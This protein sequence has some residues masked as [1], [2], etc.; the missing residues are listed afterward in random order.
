MKT[1]VLKKD[2][3]K[4]I[5]LTIIVAL[6]PLIQHQLITGTLVN[7]ILFI[8]TVLLG[9]QAG[10]IISFLPSLIALGVGFLPYVLLPMIPYIIIGNIV[11][12][13]TFNYFR[14]KY[15]LG[16]FI[17]SIFKFLFL[18]SIS[19][20]IM[21]FLLKQKI[22]YRALVMMS[23]PQLVTALLGGIIA[24]FIIKKYE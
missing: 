22:D 15:W 2:L 1:L 4:I 23:W 16:V 9:I 11:L 10:I 3:S 24:F 19:S 12:V 17:A 6:V 5:I 7:A 14:K 13:I 20:I 18:L 21:N 8:A